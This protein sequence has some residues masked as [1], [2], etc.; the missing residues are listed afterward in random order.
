MWA[1]HVQTAENL[2]NGFSKTKRNL[3][4][5]QREEKNL[6]IEEQG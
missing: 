6:S 3:Q 1:Y 2:Q 5:S 4:K